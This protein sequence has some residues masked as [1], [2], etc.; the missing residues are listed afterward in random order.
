MFSAQ[1]K[2]NNVVEYVLFLWHT[3]DLLRSLELNDERVNT[4]LVSKQAVTQEDRDRLSTWYVKLLKEMKRDGL[5]KTGHLEETEEILNELFFLHNSLLDA[6]KDADY[7][8]LWQLAEPNM[9][10]LQIKSKSMSI[11]PIELI[12]TG[13]YG[14]SA[15]RAQGKDLS[16]ETEKAISEFSAL[17]NHLGM[18]FKEYKS[19]KM[20]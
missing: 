6:L 14:A 7:K 18:R 10:E 4:E 2:T 17:L 1:H 8:K 13:L 19:G 3:E 12:L 5:Q 11:N 9:K 15:L 20:N 16:K